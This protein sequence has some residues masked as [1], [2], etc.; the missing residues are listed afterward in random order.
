MSF[1]LLLAQPEANMDD[2][3]VVP[4]GTITPPYS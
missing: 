4:L 1:V 3:N 2:I